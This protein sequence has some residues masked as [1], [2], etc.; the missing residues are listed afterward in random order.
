MC[1]VTLQ[2]LLVGRGCSL[3]CHFTNSASGGGGVACIVTLQT[4]LVGRGCSVYCHF[5]NSASG[6][7]V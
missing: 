5:T 1:I 2:T 4:L 3:Y 7:G 6:E